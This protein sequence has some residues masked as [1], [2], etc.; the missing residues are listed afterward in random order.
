MLGERFGDF[1]LTEK[2]EVSLTRYALTVKR[3]TAPF[4][5]AEAAAMHHGATVA[6][7]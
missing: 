7:E 3:L 2:T 6:D 5:S 1:S 4:R